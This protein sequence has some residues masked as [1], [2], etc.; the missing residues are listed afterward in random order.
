M[1]REAYA[2]NLRIFRPSFMFVQPFGFHL[3]VVRRKAAERPCSQTRL[4]LLRVPV[5]II[6][7]VRKHRETREI[8]ILQVFFHLAFRTQRP[9]D[10]KRTQLL[11]RI[12]KSF[13]FR[14]RRQRGLTFKG[15]LSSHFPL[16]SF[17]LQ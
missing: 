16:P 7:E 1:L 17:A 2:T 12:W 3:D 10:L 11:K 5:R 9:V 13:N 8:L 14:S 15:N 6:I 4:S